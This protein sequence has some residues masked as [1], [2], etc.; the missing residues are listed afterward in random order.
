[1]YY[2]VLVLHILICVSLILIVLLQAGKG[3]GIAGLFGG[4]GGDAL[5]SAPSGSAF[6]KKLTTIL[7]I[8]F[9][10]T[11]LLLTILTT[12]RGYRSVLQNI[13]P[14]PPVQTP[15]LPSQTPTQ[16][17]IEIPKQEKK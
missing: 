5:F 16:P 11:S 6:I 10:G 15:Q 12:A 9:A 8:S 1:M 14:P 4:G 13:P 17:P 3:S 7:A 2:I